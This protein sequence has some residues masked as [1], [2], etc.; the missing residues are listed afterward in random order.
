MW[1][2]LVP[3]DPT[4]AYRSLLAAAS[5][6]VVD[7]GCWVWTGAHT[8]QGYGTITIK[9][10]HIM[11]HRFMYELLRGPIPRGLQIDHLCRTPSCVNPGH[12][13]PVTSRENTRR[14]RAGENYSTRLACAHGHLFDV[15]NTRLRT[16]RSGSVTRVCRACER[17]RRSIPAERERR[18]LREAERRRSRLTGHVPSAPDVVR[19][20]RLCELVGARHDE[21]RSNEE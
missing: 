12:L 7:D 17:E 21:E 16:R 9:K 3:N 6:F 15:T 11:A 2:D 20:E 13:E 18:R 8:V 5:K 4:D 10:R 14:G 1:S 19:L